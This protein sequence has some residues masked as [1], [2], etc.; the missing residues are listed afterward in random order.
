VHWEG[1]GKKGLGRISTETGA[2]RDYPCGF[3]SRFEDD[4]RD[5]NA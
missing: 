2:L 1:Q 3:T 5:S 4:R